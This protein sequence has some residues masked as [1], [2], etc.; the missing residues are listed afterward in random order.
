MSEPAP[1]F[2]SGQPP[3]PGAGAPGEVPPPPVEVTHGEGEQPAAPKLPW[4]GLAGAI[5]IAALIA[6]GWWWQGQPSAIVPAAQGEPVAT[7][8]AVPASALPPGLPRAAA[9][10]AVT[11]PVTVANL[12]PA[13]AAAPSRPVPIEPQPDP[14]LLTRVRAFAISAVMPGPQGRAMIDG[15][16]RHLGDEVLPGLTLAETTVEEIVFRDQAGAHYRRRF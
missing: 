10:D 8:S 2:P 14:A 6:A 1:P 16:M 13:A 15:R 11:A 9:A 12:P 5:L 3:R 7:P 4:G